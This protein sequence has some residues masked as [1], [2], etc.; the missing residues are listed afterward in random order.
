MTPCETSNST[1]SPPSGEVIRTF[2]V[3]RILRE[4]ILYILRFPVFFLSFF[5]SPHRRPR[6]LILTP[7]FFKKQRIYDGKTKKI[8]AIEIRDEID[9][10]TLDEIYLRHGYATE[11]LKRHEEILSFYTETLKSSSQP[12]I[13]D[14]G[15]NIG[16]TSRFFANTY[17]GAQ[18]VSLEPDAHN[19]PVFRPYTMDRTIPPH[20]HRTPRLA[21]A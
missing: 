15:A 11:K 19:R 10:S 21:I 5:S 4:C 8:T 13:I 1:Q 16:L 20:H 12:L 2:S 17:P 14:C 9:F 7:P 6:H 18:I 3:H